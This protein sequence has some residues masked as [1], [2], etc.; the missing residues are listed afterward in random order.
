MS[1]S[2][3]LLKHAAMRLINRAT[4]SAMLT[5]RTVQRLLIL[6]SDHLLC[7]QTAA[8]LCRQRKVLRGFLMK[9]I[10]KKASFAP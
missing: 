5:W 2:K 3:Q 10:N 4:S 8:E 7:F 6:C 9:L 1:L